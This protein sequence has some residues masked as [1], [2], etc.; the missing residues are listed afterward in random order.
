[1]LLPTPVYRGNTAAHIEGPLAIDS[2][3]RNWNRWGADDQR[4]TLN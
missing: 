4:G 3:P 1:M 2:Q